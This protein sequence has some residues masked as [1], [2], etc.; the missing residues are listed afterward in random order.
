MRYMLGG[1]VRLQLVLIMQCASSNTTGTA[2]G[3]AIIPPPPLSLS[4]SPTPFPL[5]TPRRALP[6]PHLE[7]VMF[8]GSGLPCWAVILTT[9]AQPKPCGC[10][11]NKRHTQVVGKVCANF[12]SEKA[13]HPQRLLPSALTTL[14]Q[15]QG[16]E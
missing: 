3:S 16:V 6:H 9:L 4:I 12:L 11:T 10:T 15:V 8:Q 14:G 13:K 5:P 1:L 2:Q 7:A